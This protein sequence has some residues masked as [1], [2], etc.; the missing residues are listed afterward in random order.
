MGLNKKYINLKNIESYLSDDK[1]DL[2]FNNTDIFI[3]DNDG[4][5]EVYKMYISGKTNKEILSLIKNNKK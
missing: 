3:F 4:S 1:L 5:S 2:L